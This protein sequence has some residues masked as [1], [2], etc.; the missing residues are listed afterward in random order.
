VKILRKHGIKP[1]FQF[2]LDTVIV[3][4]HWQSL[5]LFEDVPFISDYRVPPY[6]VDLFN[7]PLLCSDICRQGAVSFP[8]SLD[9]THPSTTNLAISFACFCQPEELYFLGCDFGYRSMDRDHAIGSIY[10]GEELKK[11]LLRDKTYAT[12]S[13]LEPNFADTD[14]VMTVPVHLRTKIVV[15]Q[16]LMMSAGAIKVI[17]C[18]DGARIVGATP[19]RS[20]SIQLSEYADKVLDCRGILQGFQAARQG[21]NWHMYKQTGAERLQILKNDLMCELS[22]MSFNWKKFSQVLDNVLTRVLVE[23]RGEAGKDTRVEIYFQ[24]LVDLLKLW[25]HCLILFDNRED[26][27]AI[28]RK[29]YTLLQDVLEDLYWPEELDR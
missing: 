18:S 29:G 20:S 6:I 1:D 13:L 14:P 3:A 16:C 4:E 28:Y 15:E 21:K 19:M 11:K 22:L 26:A 8:V 7:Q 27:E 2:N 12:Q 17:N 25:Y 10:D 5:E 9:N 23:K 24:L